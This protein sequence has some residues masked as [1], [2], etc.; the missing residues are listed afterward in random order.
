[1]RGTA[2][3]ACLVLL[4]CEPVTLASSQEPPDATIAGDDHVIRVDSELAARLATAPVER[5]TLRRIIRLPASV[6]LDQTRLS[7]IDAG[8]NGRIVEVNVFGGKRVERAEVLARLTSPELTRGQVALLGALAEVDLQRRAVERA[9]ELVEAEVISQAEL[10]RR[11]KE[12]F[13]T[14][15]AVQSHRDQLGLMG[16]DPREIRQV[17]ATGSIYS[18]VAVMS[19]RAGTVIQRNVSQDQ[20]VQPGAP[21]FSIADLSRVWI[22]GQAPEG[23]VDFL[24]SAHDVRVEIPAIDARDLEGEVVYIGATVNPATR[25]VTVRTE[26]ESPDERIKPEMLATLLVV[27][28][29][30][31]RLT[32]PAAAV[33]READADHVFVRETDDRFRLARVSLEPAVDGLR[34]VETGLREGDVIVT[35][36][37]FRLNAELK[38]RLG[39]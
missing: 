32:V 12:L 22:E 19:Q 1:M 7:R 20:V 10:E 2:L 8:V 15:M 17:E 29:E 13:V 24:A 33:V 9:R 6:E 35:G 11:E 26:L 16:M 39:R 14:R 21:L 28:P 27:G 4:A 31:N 18:E 34:P 23:E 38:R 5:A 25:T 30:E 37:A 36:G 3:L